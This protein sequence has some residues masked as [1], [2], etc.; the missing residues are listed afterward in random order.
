MLKQY[1]PLVNFSHIIIIIQNKEKISSYKATNSRFTIAFPVLNAFLEKMPL[2][3]E[4][5]KRKEKKII[6]LTII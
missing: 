1:E 3:H 2:D 4:V 6:I 5:K